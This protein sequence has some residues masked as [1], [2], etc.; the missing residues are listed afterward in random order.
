M[1][2]ILKNITSLIKKKP[3]FYFCGCM[4]THIDVYKF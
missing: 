4:F 2:N 3:F 1:L